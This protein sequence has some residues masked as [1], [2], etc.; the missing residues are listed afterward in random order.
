MRTRLTVL[1]ASSRSVAGVFD[2]GEYRLSDSLNSP[3]Q[4]ALRLT[5]ASLGRLG[6]EDA[7]EPVD[8]AI[9]PKSQVALVFATHELVPPIQRRISSYVAKQTT[10]LVVLV[11]GLRIRGHAHSTFTLDPVELH[12]LVADGVSRFLVLTNARLA[13]DVE[14]TTE[15]D[16]GLALVNALHLQFV[17]R[18]AFAAQPAKAE[19]SPPIALAAE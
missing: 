1:L 17:A 9:V 7:N 2:H 14:G 6:N 13:L 8:V 4:S 18:D 3:L 5:E 11:A 19:H 16:V 10:G 12:R 15:R